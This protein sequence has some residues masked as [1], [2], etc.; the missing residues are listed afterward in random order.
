MSVSDVTVVVV[1][2][3][4]FSFAQR[5]LDSL[6]EHTPGIAN[7]VY[8]DAG[9]P[10]RTEQYIAEQ[11]ERRGFT[12]VRID[13]YVSPNHARNVGLSYVRTPYV[14]F[15][16]N[17]V[18]FS[19]AWLERL[20]ACAEETGAAIVG[21]LYHLDEGGRMTVHMAGGD[22]EIAEEDGKRVY[23]ETHRY[24]G[25]PLET[26]PPL[27]RTQI[28][29]VEFHAMLVRTELFAATGLFDEAILSVN[30]HVDYCM[31]AR[32]LGR[33][34]YL[35]PSSVVTHVPAMRLEPS[36][37]PFFML[38]WS[39]RWNRSTAQHFNAKYRLDPKHPL[40][41]AI[42]RHGRHYRCKRLRLVHDRPI[43]STPE[44]VQQRL[45]NAAERCVNIAYT[46]LAALRTPHR[47]PAPALAP[48]AFAERSSAG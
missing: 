29:I 44:L 45:I 8:V 6:L 38:R 41:N 25:V 46:T 48:H 22:V 37:L 14:V 10:A 21:P 5:S 42:V 1:P 26:A 13:H 4:R 19:P 16:D 20:L 2:R 3:E 28:G 39:E 24:A 34:I 30:E 11:V 33:T 9:S 32:A 15:V 43:S 36:D 7:L 40:N 23:R 12:L 47:E 35:E 27:E 31:R 18:L 17:D